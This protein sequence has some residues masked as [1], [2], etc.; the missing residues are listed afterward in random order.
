MTRF[1]K[2][3]LMNTHPFSKS[4][5]SFKVSP[6]LQDQI[7]YTSQKEVYNEA[8]ATL[9]RLMRIKVS[10]SQ[11]YRITTKY[12]AEISEEIKE[13]IPEF[14][15]DKA[16]KIYAQMDGGMVLTDEGWH[17]AKVGRIFRQSDIVKISQGSERQKIKES[18]YVAQMGE[19][20]IFVAAFGEALQ[21]YKKRKSR[22][23]FINDGAVWID[24]WINKKFPS[25]ISILDYYHATENIAK[26][27]KVLIKGKEQFAEWF[28]KQKECL[29]KS[30]IKEVINSI[31]KLTPKNE[32]QVD[33]KMSLIKYIR[34]NKKRMDYKRYRD[35]GLQIGSGAIEA[36]HRTVV[37]AR[38]KKSGQ[39]WSNKGAQN[40][41]NLRVAFKSDRWDLVKNKICSQKAA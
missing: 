41:L 9:E 39:R 16:D 25:A 20:T 1:G 11:C 6:Y 3:E 31:L 21:L 4:I 36:A 10:T 32:E 27:G 15:L 38:M 7:V 37:Q 17:E 12:G 5:K 33:L 18:Q 28:N 23:V 30:E 8:S 34:K 22:L 14:E 24:N 2:I 19:H 26:V 40:M 29:L 35:K 13:N